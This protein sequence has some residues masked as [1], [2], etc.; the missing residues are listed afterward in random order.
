MF[1]A[2]TQADSSPTRK[3][4]GTGLGLAI[5]SRLVRMMGGQIAVESEVGIGSTFHFDVPLG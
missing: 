3:D 2:F 5:A 1:D 4:G